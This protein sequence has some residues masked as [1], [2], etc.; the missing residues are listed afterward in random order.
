VIYTLELRL[1]E[2]PKTVNHANSYQSTNGEN[3]QV[4]AIT[5]ERFVEIY[6]QLTN[7]T[8]QSPN[9]TTTAFAGSLSG[10][11]SVVITSNAI[12]CLMFHV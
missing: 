3:M 5:T 8:E 4:T 1:D 11:G 7:I 9:L 6:E 12:E 2:L 10:I